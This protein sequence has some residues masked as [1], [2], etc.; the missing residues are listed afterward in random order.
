MSDMPSPQSKPVVFLVDTDDAE[1]DAMRAAVERLGC[2][3]LPLSAMQLAISLLRNN[4]AC[5]LVVLAA[6]AL[7][8][9][10]SAFDAL[11]AARPGGAPKTIVSGVDPR[12]KA[13]LHCLNKGAMDFL[14]K[15]VDA[16]ALANAVENALFADADGTGYKLY[17]EAAIV[18]SSHVGGWIEIT[19]SSKLGMLRRVQRFSDALFESRLP[20]DVCEDLKMAVEEVGRNAVEW[21]NKFDPGKVLRLSYCL[22]HDRVVLKMEDEGEGF[23]PESVP[24]PTADPVKTMR[25]R[26][27]A[28]KR[29]GGYGVYMLQKLVDEV[30]YNE[31]GNIVLLI[32]YLP[33]EAPQNEE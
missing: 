19:A 29:P 20:R 21:G 28:G 30:V 32:K 23:R 16:A 3:V 12:A 33:Q 27:E 13:V 22:F 7:G 25:D 6:D 1:R 15:P 4:A 8:E 2:A 24:D 17:P 18:A 10:A 11:L 26:L 31:K 5:D 14:S 9:D